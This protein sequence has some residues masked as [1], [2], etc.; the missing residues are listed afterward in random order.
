[1]D[2]HAQKLVSKIRATAALVA[3][4]V[5]EYNL[6]MNIA[7]INLHSRGNL[8]Y[9]DRSR[10]R[11]EGITNGQKIVTVSRNEVSQTF[12][13]EQK[14]VSQSNPMESQS[15]ID[16]LY[17]LSDIR[18]SFSSTDKDTLVYIGK[19]HIDEQKAHHFKGHFPILP[20]PGNLR[21]RMPIE[22]DLFIDRVSCLLLKRI[23]TQTGK[24]TLVSADYKIME[25]NGSIHDSLFSIDVSSPDIRKVD[26]MDITNTLFFSD[27]KHS[28]ASMN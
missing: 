3:S 4:F 5:A 12:F 2:E 1:M 21:V 10:Y 7:G 23:W 16:L 22:V 20:I 8:Y 24:G 11:V 15:P 9:A 28:G 18:D 17:G 13:V 27:E 25:T 26:L 14:I 6:T 19:A